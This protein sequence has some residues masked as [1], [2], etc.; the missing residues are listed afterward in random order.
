MRGVDHT[1]S[2]HVA[3]RGAVALVV[4]LLGTVIYLPTTA[5]SVNIAPATVTSQSCS[6]PLNCIIIE[7]PNSLTNNRNYIYGTTD[8]GATWQ[9]IPTSKALEFG[10]EVTCAPGG[11]CF[12]SASQYFVGEVVNDPNFLFVETVR[13]SQWV[14]RQI[15]LGQSGTED[16]TST[17]ALSCPQANTCYYLRSNELVSTSNDGASW[18]THLIRLPVTR[19]P[20]YLFNNQYFDFTP[21]SCPEVNYCFVLDYQGGVGPH[22]WTEII[23]TSNGGRTWSPVVVASFPQVLGSRAAALSITCSSPSVC[24]MSAWNNTNKESWVLVTDDGGKTW[25]TILQPATGNTVPTYVEVSCLSSNVCLGEWSPGDASQTTPEGIMSTDGG[26]SWTADSSAPLVGIV[27]CTWNVVCSTEYGTS[28]AEESLSVDGISW[29]A[30][31]VPNATVG[32]SCGSAGIPSGVRGLAPLRGVHAN[33]SHRRG[34]KVQ[35]GYEWSRAGS[36]QARLGTFT[37]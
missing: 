15:S 25:N 35:R 8:G 17:G 29:T 7:Q 30:E 9:F 2:P 36:T 5:G 32:S 20:G 18:Q 26:R 27:S 3:P 6:T 28:F 10:A 16:Q 22:N 1:R 12:V 37:R 21:L 24:V 19:P 13:G 31:C 33:V 4:L 14:Q 11:A 34:S 23:R